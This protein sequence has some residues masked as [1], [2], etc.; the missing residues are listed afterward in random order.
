MSTVKEQLIQNLAPD[1]KQ[2][3]C[4]ITV[5]GVGNVGMAC[6]I[7]ILLKGLADELALV[8]ADENKLKG[9][10]LDLLHGSLFLSTPKIVFGK[11]P[12]WSGVNIAGVT[13]KSLNPAIGS[14]S[15]KE[16]WKTVH[17]Q[18]L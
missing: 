6:A 7:S 8:D 4:K 2:S 1:E 15:D 13:L 3:R 5:V 18:W 10:A 11:V 9:E 12:I 17:K 16:Q 14:D